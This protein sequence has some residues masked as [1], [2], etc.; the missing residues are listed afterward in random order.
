MK[1]IYFVLYD[2]FKDPRVLCGFTSLEKAN[3]YAKR[4]AND[5]IDDDCTEYKEK[6]GIFDC[7]NIGW[8]DGDDVPMH[9]WVRYTDITVEIAPPAILYCV[10]C[11]ENSDRKMVSY[12]VDL[13]TAN[14][15]ASKLGRSKEIMLNDCAQYDKVFDERGFVKIKMINV[16]DGP[17]EIT[18]VYVEAVDIY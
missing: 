13:A 3:A 2:D 10:F 6:I 15:Y 8:C 14:S 18:S 17:I 11:I 16:P 1:N 9:V 4:V 12:F 5:L 7:I